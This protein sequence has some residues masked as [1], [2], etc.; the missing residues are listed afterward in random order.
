MLLKIVSPPSFIDVLKG[1]LIYLCR[2]TLLSDYLMNEWLLC[3]IQAFL[4]LGNKKQF[5]SRGLPI[6]KLLFIS[7]VIMDLVFFSHL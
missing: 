6:G 2:I 7:K 3:S 4:T 1:M 5:S